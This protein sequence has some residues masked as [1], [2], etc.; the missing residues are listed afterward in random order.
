VKNLKK[1]I[2]FLKLENKEL[3]TV[4][5]LPMKKIKQ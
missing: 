3:L 2:L 1:K 5:Y 4:Y